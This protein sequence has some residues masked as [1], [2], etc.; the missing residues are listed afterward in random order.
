MK[1]RKKKQLTASAQQAVAL[2]AVLKEG[3]ESY[4][5][6][7]VVDAQSTV[8]AMNALARLQG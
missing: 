8:H 1:G 6:L 2:E 3:A 5:L 4:E 7:V